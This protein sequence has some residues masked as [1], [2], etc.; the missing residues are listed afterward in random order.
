MLVASVAGLLLLTAGA[1]NSGEA[2][3]RY[4]TAVAESPA[5]GHPMPVSEEPEPA[6]LPASQPASNPVAAVEETLRA[7]TA[8]GTRAGAG[9]AHADHHENEAEGEGR[10]AWEAAIDFYVPP[11]QL[12]VILA[13]LAVALAAAA[14]GLSIKRWDPALQV[15]P[16]AGGEVPRSDAG[17]VMPI[18]IAESIR[19]RAAFAATPQALA[20][21][22]PGRL[23]V[24]ASLFAILAAGAGVW[25]VGG[26]SW[27]QVRDAVALIREPD[28][29]R[30]LWHVVS[31]VVI[32]VL[33][34]LLAITVRVSRQ[35]R[36]LTIVLAAIVLVAVAWQVWSGILMTYDSHE[37][38]LT[39]FSAPPTTMPSAH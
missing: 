39:G 14:L 4:G 36:L 16:P 35:A 24:F 13:G 28:H 18:D 38:P 26:L 33:P 30:L 5:Q 19:P 29:G 20:R 9:H 15:A 6:A 2:I 1:W 22:F 31:G 37:G 17:Q 25:S 8:P 3:Y 27:A 11:L 34:L 12:H 7:T 32:V 23:W 21:P 10:P